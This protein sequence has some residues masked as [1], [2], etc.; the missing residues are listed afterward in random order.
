MVERNAITEL[1]AKDASRQTPIRE[2]ARRTRSA[3]VHT[4]L[5]TSLITLRAMSENRKQEK[6]Y[7]KEVDEALPL[8]EQ[9]AK[10]RHSLHFVRVCYLCLI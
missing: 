2:D 4:F 1:G 3:R 10:V 5:R 9:T 8:A 7:T 6:D